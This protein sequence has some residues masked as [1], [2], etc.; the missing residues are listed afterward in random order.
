MT[1]SSGAVVEVNECLIWA[2]KLGAEW[3]ESFSARYAQSGRL[4]VIT[5]S[6]AGNRWSVACDDMDHARWLAGQAI[7]FGGVPKAAIKVRAVQ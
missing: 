2:T 4:T 3:W 6:V 7:A 5:P 1:K